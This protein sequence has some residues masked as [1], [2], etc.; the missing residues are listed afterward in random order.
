MRKYISYILSV[1]LMF[2]AIAV[3][4][5]EYEEK[6][7]ASVSVDIIEQE[8]VTE[9]AEVNDITENDKI[10]SEAVD[11]QDLDAELG[12]EIE[13]NNEEEPEITV[14]SESANE[15]DTWTSATSMGTSRAGCELMVVD[16]DLY[17]VG[18]MSSTGYLY[19]IEKYSD[20]GAAWQTVTTI[21]ANIKGFGAVGYNSKIYIIGGYDDDYLNTVQVYDITTNSWSSIVPMNEKRDQPAVLCIDNKIY[22]FG[23]R[24]NSG[25]VN[26]YEYFDFS[27]NTWNTVT[28]GYSDTMIRVGAHAQYIDGY[29]CIY[30]GI[31]RDYNYAGVDMYLASALTNTDEIIADGYEWISA[32]WGADKA[33]L[34]MWDRS[35][36]TYNIKELSVSNGE[37]S[38]SN[39]VLSN[40]SAV[41]K[42]SGYAIY[43]GY[44]YA[45][46]G[47]NL[48][49]KSYLSSVNK[50]SVYYGDYSIGDG[51]IS[52]IVT[53]DG[54]SITL[55]V[56]AGREYMLFVNAKNISSFDDYEFRIEYPDNVFTVVDGCTLTANKDTNIGIVSGTDINI[57]ENNANGIAFKCTEQLSSAVT[58]SVNAVLLRAEASGQRTIRYSMV[59]E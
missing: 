39:V 57:T 1:V 5:E 7:E 32:A 42:Y 41:A 54:N 26:S 46:G 23:G 13:L 52:S 24:N 53:S 12:N 59:E 9:D 56:E 16:G 35:T 34:F 20:T 15:T 31:D 3:S 22:A 28:T 17:A 50:Y 27:D 29:V 47:Y 10:I 30:G 11:L 14:L 2:S 49:S 25:F 37:I 58:K 55:N 40:T 18:G 36:G 45:L 8:A 33:L 6:G 44:L 19:T 38:L 51:V 4:A 48:T 43:N 21:P